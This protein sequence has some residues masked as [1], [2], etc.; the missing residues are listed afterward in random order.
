MITQ[1]RLTERAVLRH[2]LIGLDNEWPMGDYIH[3]LA[4]D[5]RGRDRFLL[6]A[7]AQLIESGLTVPDA[8]SQSRSLFSPELRSAVTVGTQN[9]MLREVLRSDL[10]RGP[11]FHDF[12]PFSWFL[13]PAIV[14]SVILLRAG[15]AMLSIDVAVNDLIALEDSA[16]RGRL[17]EPWISFRDA[18]HAWRMITWISFGVIIG[19]TIWVGIRPFVSSVR[20][21]QYAFRFGWTESLRSHRFLRFL[22]FARKHGK[23]LHGVISSLARC[24]DDPPI[25]WH[26]LFVRNEMDHGVS[27]WKAMED[28]G[29]LKRAEAIGIE[30]SEKLNNTVWMLDFLARLKSRIGESRERLTIF[31]VCLFAF[32]TFSATVLYFAT[33]F[34][35]SLY[36]LVI[37]NAFL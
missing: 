36:S 14:L 6:M 20:R 12:A 34:F 13:V 2:I 32:A 31:L 37:Q 26:L 25:R 30:A 17:P 16:H 9:G 19:A 11:R 7:F 22:A 35:G 8:I 15:H 3:S 4:H 10:A 27:P 21:G 28:R 23:P 18:S 5:F 33:T 29:L 24:W 1:R